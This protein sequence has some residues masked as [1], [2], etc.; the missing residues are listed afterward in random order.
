M[1]TSA[2]DARTCPRLR[3]CFSICALSLPGVPPPVDAGAA[4]A[5][6]LPAIGAA[7]LGSV[8]TS[9]VLVVHGTT[10]A[11]SGRRGALVPVSSLPGEGGTSGPCGLEVLPL[12]EAGSLLL[13]TGPRPTV[14]ARGD[15]TCRRLTRRTPRSRTR[16]RRCT[17]CRAPRTRARRGDDVHVV[18]GGRRASRQPRGA[19][20]SFLHD[21]RQDDMRELH[22]LPGPTDHEGK[23][24]LALHADR[25]RPRRPLGGQQRSRRDGVEASMGIERPRPARGKGKGARPIGRAWGDRQRSSQFHRR[26]SPCFGARFARKPCRNEGC[27]ARSRGGG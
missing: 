10:S 4:R 2:R 13:A 7:S 27:S 17:R 16:A 18:R 3:C 9:S 21:S 20:R 5:H 15:G 12:R 19:S 22:E 24:D 6:T 14:D 26:R 8:S 25:P 1:G 23:D 11:A